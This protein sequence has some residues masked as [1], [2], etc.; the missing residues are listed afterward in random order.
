MGGKRKA[1]PVPSRSPSTAM[2]PFENAFERA[3]GMKTGDIGKSWEG[4]KSL[5]NHGKAEPAM[6]ELLER[7]D[8]RLGYALIGAGC[9]LLFVLT[10]AASAEYVHVVNFESRT[11]GDIVGEQLPTLDPPI[12]IPIAAYSFILHAV[13]TFAL[14]LAQEFAAF[15]IARLTG[16][17]G[18]F[19]QQL[20]LSSVVWLAVSMSWSVTL[21]GPL[22]CLAFVAIASLILVTFLYLMVYMNGRAY[23]IAHNIS[24]LHGATIAFVLVVPKIA[25]WMLASSALATLMGLPI[26]A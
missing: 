14:N 11:V 7:A 1:E 16:G 12:L 8:E 18:T 6:K 17:T 20:Y 9:L 2:R 5:F 19:R 23:A 26:G 25:I 3:F 21:L 15:H 13:L 4:A 24:L 10:F 22:Y